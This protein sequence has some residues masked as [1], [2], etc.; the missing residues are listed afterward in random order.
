VVGAWSSRAWVVL[1]FGLCVM[2]TNRIFAVSGGDRRFFMVIGCCRASFG[3]G[4]CG[5]RA[6]SD[7]GF[8][9][10]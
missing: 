6:A 7:D 5:T 2:A 1:C 3:G 8:P 10:R 9:R 4:A